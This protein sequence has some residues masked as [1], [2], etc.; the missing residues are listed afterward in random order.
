MKILYIHQ[1][2]K[3]P[4]ESGSTRSYWI[5][6]E[7]F[8]RGHEVTII[9]GT[10]KKNQKIGLFLQDGVQ[11]KYLD[12]FYTQKMSLLKRAYAFLKFT[13]QSI[14][15]ISKNH[16][17]FDIIY[18]TSTPL[19]TGIP[20]LFAKYLF[21]IPFI[22]EVRDVWPE[23]PIQMGAIK[24]TFII[25]LLRGLESSI[26]QNSSSIITLSPDMTDLLKLNM[27]KKQ[28]NIYTIS[29]MSKTELFWKRDINERII[30]KYGLKAD[31]FKIVYFGAVGRAN[32][33][34]NAIKLFDLYQNKYPQS[35]VQFII[36]GNGSEFE[37][38][39]SYSLSLRYVQ[40]K[41]IPGQSLKVVS[42]LVNA[43]DASLV[44]FLNIPILDSN[45]P[46]KLFDS[47]SAELPLIV[48]SNGWTRTLVENNNCGVYY[49]F[50]DFNS[51]EI[52]IE[53]L[54]IDKN[55]IEF[56]RNARN[57]ALNKFDK[58]ILC[59]EVCKVIESTYKDL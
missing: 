42:E 34:H 43:C 56:S 27:V 18:A 48:N 58:S 20:A 29:N 5:S 46:N 19:T 45:S 51:F 52:A 14:A 38:L 54:L 39:K 2:F 3:T 8:K 33:L 40:I 4:S 21:N 30:A 31:G 57:L 6:K 9:S 32:G 28:S 49:K 24:N 17:K 13:L 35:K 1:Y 11:V 7:L 12:T 47:L 25:N 15:Y 41:F 22:F 10:T 59:G 53:K 26:Y 16:K 55:R 50:D 36:I 37:S 44:S 23:V